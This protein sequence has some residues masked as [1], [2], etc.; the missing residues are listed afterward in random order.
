MR[1]RERLDLSRTDFC[2]GLIWTK[3][4][5]AWQATFEHHRRYPTDLTDEEW[6][7]IM[8]F[9]PAPDKCGRPP[10]MD[11]REVL[12]AIRYMA[13]SGGSWR[14]MPVHFGL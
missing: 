13:C 1:M 6:K 12:N 2:I 10:K 11:L 5:Q 3:E 14:I 8:P 9:L 7:R 4:H